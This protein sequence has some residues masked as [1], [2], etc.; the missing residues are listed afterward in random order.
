MNMFEENGLGPESTTAESAG[1]GVQENTGTET[2]KESNF[3]LSDTLELL[4]RVHEM[5]SDEED[6]DDCFD[7]TD[8]DMDDDDYHNKAVSL[9]LRGRNQEAAKLCIRGLKKFPFCVDL[10]A[11]TVMYSA[12]TGD[13]QT[14]ADYY[15]RLKS[16]IPFSRW[17]W[18]AFTFSFDYLLKA[19]PIANEEEC[20]AIIA[21]YREYIPYT[22]K[23]D[24]AESELEAALGNAER[25]LDVL[26]EAIRTRP[27]ACQCALRLA[28]MQM[29]RG[30]FEEVVATTSYGIAASA[31]PQPSI[32]VSYLY[33]LRTL[34]KD[35]LL[36]RKECAGESISREELDALK[37]EYALLDSEFGGELSHHIRTIRTRSRMLKFVRAE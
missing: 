31:E 26:R 22:E 25:S 35:N 21:R 6:D 9:A 27:N 10:L 15:A 1:E 5:V 14:A 34:A 12:K 33:Y 37:Q 23:A 2:E 19:D 32:N 8:E 18:R 29:D 17:N 13:M 16:S 4:S 11:D 36:H 24:M 30:L 20:R 28:D 7:N 3:S